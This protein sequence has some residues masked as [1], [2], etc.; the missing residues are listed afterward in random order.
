MTMFVPSGSA[1]ES[2]DSGANTSIASQCQELA[3]LIARHT[4]GK[5]NGFHHTAIDRLDFGQESVVASTLAT[6]IEDNPSAD[7]QHRDR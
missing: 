5:G 7:L 1:T 3:T 4:D 2:I 6:S